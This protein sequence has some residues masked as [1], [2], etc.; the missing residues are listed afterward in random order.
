MD[1]SLYYPQYSMKWLW[2]LHPRFEQEMGNV[3]GVSLTAPWEGPSW[4]K[5]TGE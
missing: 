5:G 4:P 1:V 2:P 3:A